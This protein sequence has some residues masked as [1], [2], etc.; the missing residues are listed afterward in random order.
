LAGLADPT[1]LAVTVAASLGIPGVR[2]NDGLAA[3]LTA[4][5]LLLVRDNGEHLIEALADLIRLLLSRCHGLQIL[6]TSREILTIPGETIWDVT[7]LDPAT[8]A[9]ELFIARAAAALPNWTPDADERGAIERI[10]SLLDGLP[11]AVELAAARMRVLSAGQVADGLRDRFALLAG[12]VRGMPA[13]QRDLGQ[14]VEWSCR[15]LEPAEFS[16]FRALAVFAGDFDLDGAAAVSDHSPSATWP[17]LNGL[18]RRSLL[19][20]VAGTS[21]RRYRM[22][23]TLRE[24][25]LT[26]SSV[27]DQERARELDRYYIL[28]RAQTAETE[29]RGTD[30]DAAIE[31]MRRDGAEHRVAFASAA[32][33][34]DT[35]FAL[36]LV[37]ALG[38]FWYRTGGIEEG[39]RHTTNALVIGETDWRQDDLESESSDATAALRRAAALIS[40]GGLTYLS[41]DPV[42][43]AAT[44]AASAALAQRARDIPAEARATAWQAHMVSF[45][46]PRLA[47]QLAEQVQAVRA[48]LSVVDYDRYRDAGRS[49]NR[50]D[51]AAL[52]R[53]LLR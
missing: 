1:L 19:S 32:A 2:D 43:A 17:L 28:E 38:W 53:E 3:V 36:D 29:I 11:L 26:R 34:A 13:H 23:Q 44:L 40:L 27:G 18:V 52:L 12:G 42:G 31:R 41:G 45:S 30:A 7:P 49:M 15:T 14:M 35:E 22:L 25:A 20:A 37:G 4:Q 8:D 21:P 10:C 9:I 6:L 51:V 16:L 24:W 47:I 5:Q 39:L 33:A 50:A 48:A 46:S